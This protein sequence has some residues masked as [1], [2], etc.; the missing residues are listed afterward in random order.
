MNAQLARLI[1]KTRIQAIHAATNL[2]GAINT[3]GALTGPDYDEDHADAWQAIASL[4]AAA[5]ALRAI[6]ARH[7]DAVY[8]AK[9]EATE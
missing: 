7:G 3:T 1:N 9:A 5:R 8:H 4:T 2:E 6:L